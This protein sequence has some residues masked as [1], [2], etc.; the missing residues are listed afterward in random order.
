MYSES[1]SISLTIE[2]Y[3]RSHCGTVE[4]GTRPK[5]DIS[6]DELVPRPLVVERLKKIFNRIG[7]GPGKLL[8][9]D[10][11]D[12]DVEHFGKAFG[13][14]LNFNEESISS[15][16][17]DF[18]NGQSFEVIKQS[19]LAEVEKK[20]NTVQLLRKQ[21]YHEVGRKQSRL[22]ELDFTT[23]M[24]FFDNY[25]EADKVLETNIFSYH[26]E[27]NIVTFRSQSVESYVRE[28]ADI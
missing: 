14:S 15:L 2:V 17:D 9:S 7:M 13:K 23:F 19:I 21:L 5:I 11:K 1:S 6:D 12:K 24:E 20:F 28:K 8:P 4:I 22:K 3:F 25:E 18:L 10:P 16:A 26:P 27:K